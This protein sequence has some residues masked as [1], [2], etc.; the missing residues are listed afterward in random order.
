VLKAPLNKKSTNQLPLAPTY[1]GI[2]YLTNR[3]TCGNVALG[4]LL[5][6]ATEL[7]SDA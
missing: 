3:S 6:E 5:K 4:V 1:F 2:R 7:R